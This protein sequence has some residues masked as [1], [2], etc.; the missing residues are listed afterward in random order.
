MQQ[1]V[2]MNT[3]NDS[4]SASFRWQRA[5]FRLLTVFVLLLVGW[6]LVFGQ[7]LWSMVV[8]WERSETFAHGFMIPLI[9][10]WL[11]WRLRHE[12]VTVPL[13]PCWPAFVPLL[14][15]SAI[16][17]IALATGV[18][19]AHQ[20]AAVLILPMLVLLVLGWRLAWSLAFPLLY[21]VF[22]VPFGEELIPLLQ[23]ITAKITVFAL[24]LTGIPVFLSGLFIEIPTGNFEVAVACSGIRYLIASFAIGTLYAY[25]TYQKI[26]RRLLFVLASLLVPILANGI[27]AYLIVMIAHL[28]DMKYATGADHLIYGWFFFGLV[29]ML[30]FWVGNFWREDIATVRL[31]FAGTPSLQQKNTSLVMLSVGLLEVGL[32]IGA[33]RLQAEPA[34]APADKLVVQL[35]AWQVS[36]IKPAW[37]PDYQN[38]DRASL[39]LLDRPDLLPIGLYVANYRFEKQGKELINQT[40]QLYNPDIW[41][42]AETKTITQSIDSS[43]YRFNITELRSQAGTKRRVIHWY[44]LDQQHATDPVMVKLLQG[45]N[46]LRGGN[47]NSTLFALMLDYD[48][49]AMADQQLHLFFRTSW[50]G[51]QKIVPAV[52]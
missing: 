50:S 52:N 41:S 11:I 6:S 9:S 19:V 38:A 12:L 24:Q 4:Q 39:V 20:M 10:L 46:K 43:D 27:R 37:E 1:A 5:E 3:G 7:S 29:M 45:W 17:L 13:A 18:Q 51:L 31:S 44:Q 49:P 2:V 15:L 28:S 35:P 36:E 32:I 40:N 8:I 22:C 21:L 33:H 34:L 48:D 14:G 30:M 23:Q 42:P 16:W 25:L 26:S 47:Q